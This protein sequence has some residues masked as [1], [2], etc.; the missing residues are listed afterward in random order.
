MFIPHSAV[1]RAT[2]NNPNKYGRLTAHNKTSASFLRQ[3]AR[4]DESD[5]IGVLGV[6]AGFFTNTL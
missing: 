6:G 3:K 5:S 4:R 1:A 2:N